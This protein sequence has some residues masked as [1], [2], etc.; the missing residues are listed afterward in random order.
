MNELEAIRRF[1]AGDVSGEFHHRDHVHVAWMYLKR[2]PLAEVLERF[3]RGVLQ[4]AT[5]RGKPEMYHETITWA[6]LFV[7]HDRIEERGVETSFDEFARRN[8]D[9]LDWKGC[10]RRYYTQE[11]L[12]SDRARRRFVLPEPPCESRGEPE[13]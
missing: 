13:S 8:N 3:S 10:L 12:D 2:F 6:L 7:I 4:L 5:L 9:L 11:E 1:E